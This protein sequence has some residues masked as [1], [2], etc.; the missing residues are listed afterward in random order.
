MLTGERVQ[1]DQSTLKIGTCEMSAPYLASDE[2]SCAHYQFCA[3]GT[4]YRLECEG[5]RLYDPSTGFCGY[6]FII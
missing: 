1:S 3:S 4:N 5:D 6:A 2:Q